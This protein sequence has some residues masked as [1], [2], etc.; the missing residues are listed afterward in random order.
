MLEWKILAAAFS[1]LLVVSMV[2][3]GNTGFGDAFGGIA[4]KIT[5]WLGGSP[6]NIPGGLTGK[7]GSNAVSISLFPRNF[8]LSPGTRL[9]FTLGE[10]SFENFNG[11]VSVDYQSGKISLREKGSSF[12]VSSPIQAFTI[13]SIS[14]PKLSYQGKFAVLSSQSNIENENGSLDMQGFSGAFSISNSSITLSGNV[15]KITGDGW[16]VG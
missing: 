13:Q 16:T 9:N 7:P 10:S 11:E 1:A 5:D 14:L 2:L 4:G 12:V 6:V 3:A 15:T 8:T